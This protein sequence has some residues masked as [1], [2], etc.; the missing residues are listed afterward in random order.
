MQIAP[1]K[2]RASLQQKQHLMFFLRSLWCSMQAHTLEQSQRAYWLSTF[3]SVTHDPVRNHCC[4]RWKKGHWRLPCRWF[5]TSFRSCRWNNVGERQREVRSNDWCS[6]LHACYT[7]VLMQVLRR[8]PREKASS[9][10]LGYSLIWGLS[11]ARDTLRFW[12][13]GNPSSLLQPSDL[14]HRLPCN[15][16]ALIPEEMTPGKAGRGPAPSGRAQ[17]ALPS[18]PPPP[19]QGGT[20]P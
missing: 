6:H 11:I 15:D 1:R 2:E 14:C 9:T 12:K 8:N 3:P 4:Q 17:K 5:N 10:A 7:A 16:G 20:R 18:S 19:P 13:P